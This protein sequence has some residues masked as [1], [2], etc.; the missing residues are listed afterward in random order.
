MDMIPNVHFEKTTLFKK[1]SFIF[2]VIGR[3]QI[4]IRMFGPNEDELKQPRKTKN[5]AWVSVKTQ[6]GI[7]LVTPFAF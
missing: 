4:E 5:F 2:A 7:T 1:V 3:V 6:K